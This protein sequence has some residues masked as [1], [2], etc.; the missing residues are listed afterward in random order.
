MEG[1][2]ERTRATD[3]AGA[4]AIVV[5]SGGRVVAPGHAA[6]SEWLDADRFYGGV[7]LFKAGRAPRLVFTGGWSSR[8]P[9]DEP[10]GAILRGYARDLGIPDSSILVTGRV[11]TTAEEAVAVAE[12]LRS[13]ESA[14]PSAA[15]ST[16]RDSASILLVTSAF[17]LPRARRVFEREGFT[18]VPFPVDFRGAAGGRIGILSFVPNA[19]ALSGTEIA[20]REAYGRAFYALAAPRR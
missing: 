10:E 6:I 18:V 15:A 13:R 7:E 11:T 12:L 14:A 9:I 8:S 16:R 3:V 1:G 2:A 4:S 20:L 5:L 19:A 17:H